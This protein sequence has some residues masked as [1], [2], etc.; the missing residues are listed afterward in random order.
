[1]TNEKDVREWYER[2]VEERIEDSGEN[3]YDISR[4]C[5]FRYDYT[6]NY[7]RGK[8]F[9]KLWSLILLAEYLS[10]SVND[11]LGYEELDDVEMY[12]RLLASKVYL[13]EDEFAVRFSKRLVQIMNDNYVSPDELHEYSKISL[14]AINNWIGDNPET[15]PS[16]M[17]L[18]HICDALDCTPSDLL[19]Y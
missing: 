12:E 10:C 19:G 2:E 13:G 9:P 8:P 15:L 16:V 7:L 3:I 5:H 11:L 14:N 1:M 17:Q 18:I 6:R 4:F